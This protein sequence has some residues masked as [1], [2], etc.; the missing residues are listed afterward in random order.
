[1]SL[2][3]AKDL[4]WECDG[5]F[6]EL[7]NELSVLNELSAIQEWELVI[8]KLESQGMLIVRERDLVLGIMKE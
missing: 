4:A 2:P 1:M 6:D 8:E 7:D 3:T 5:P